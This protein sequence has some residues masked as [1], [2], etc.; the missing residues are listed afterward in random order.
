M[1]FEI[2]YTD[3]RSSIYYSKVR[4]VFISFK[5]LRDSRM[6][7]F[8][9]LREFHDISVIPVNSYIHSSVWRDLHKAP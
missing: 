2:G 1:G 7:C 9:F 8:H 3:S 6:I 4:D 5:S